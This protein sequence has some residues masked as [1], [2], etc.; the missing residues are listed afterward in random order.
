MLSNSGGVT[1]LSESFEVLSLSFTG[2]YTTWDSFTPRKYKVN[3]TRT[4]TYRCASVQ[5]PLYCS[6]LY[7]IS[8]IPC[9][10]TVIREA[11]LT[12]AL[13]MYFTNIRTGLHNLLSQFLRKIY[14][15]LLLPYLGL[16][17]DVITGRLK[18]LWFRKP[19][20]CF[21]EHPLN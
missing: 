14:V 10:K 12:T 9:F 11:L 17:S 20:G 3:L 16:Q 19:Q 1:N 5:N 13:M 8:R 6:P 15:I 21:S 2:L 18:S 7:P 4:L